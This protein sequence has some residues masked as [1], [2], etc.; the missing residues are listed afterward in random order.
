M[1]NL[2]HVDWTNSFSEGTSYLRFWTTND[3][4]RRL[5]PIKVAVEGDLRPSFFV[6]EEFVSVLEKTT[7]TVEP[8]TYMAYNGQRARRVILESPEK[9]QDFRSLVGIENTFEADVPFA[10]RIML[11]KGISLEIPTRYVHVD[12]EVDPSEGMPDETKADRRILSIATKENTGEERFFCEDNEPAM[13]AKFL[14]YLDSFSVVC[15]FN[16]NHFDWPYL[17]NRCKRLG[18]DYWW[19]VHVH[20]DLLAMYKYVLQNRQDRYSLDHIAKEEK[21]KAQKLNIDPKKLMVYFQTERERLKEYNL[22]DVQVMHELDQKLHMVEIVFN[23]ASI[24]HTNVKD[25]V[26]VFDK[27]YKEF[28]TSI[29]VDG[30]VLSLSAKRPERIVWKSREFKPGKVCSQCQAEMDKAETL[31]PKCGYDMKEKRFSGALVLPPAPGTHKNVVMLDVASLYPTIIQSFNMGP[32]TFR[33]DNGGDIQ[34]PIGRGS[35]TASPK[36]LF[37]EALEHV[38]TIR[39]EYKRQMKALDPATPEWKAA[40]AMDYSYKVLANSM[41]GVIGSSFS[42]YYNKDIAEN[43][44]LTGQTTLNFLRDELTRVGLKVVLGDTDSVAFVMP[45]MD[46]EKARLLAERLSNQTADYLQT[47]SGVRPTLFRLDVDKLCLSMFIP[48]DE[49]GGVKKRYAAFVVWQGVPTFYVMMKGFEAVRHDSSQGQKDFQ[50]QGLMLNLSDSSADAKQAFVE[51]WKTKL[52]A[53]ELVEQVTIHKGLGK[54]P[55]E[56]K[57]MTPYLR[58]GKILEAQGKIVLHRGD[59]IAYIKIGPKPEQVTPVVSGER[60]VLTREEYAYIFDAQFLPLAERL[61]I[62]TRPEVVKTPRKRRAAP[63]NTI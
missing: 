17:M 59:K 9:I 44:T 39:R 57:V 42:R 36:S 12:I 5:P 47:L 48:G 34:S 19:D 46:I 53:G 30:L 50:L 16:G 4:G 14:L 3:A 33:E 23:I 41:Y 22:G 20:L 29:A 18:I 6:R 15:T 7:A 27:S 55:K 49:K 38:L 51:S 60:P 52:Y 58:V 25:L 62:P 2:Y 54:D 37:S 56:Y 10:R 11:D 32:E 35:F 43:I 1:K 31:C 24:S 8:K 61:G 21:L 63:L 40:Y 26:R 45:D 13:I 28:N